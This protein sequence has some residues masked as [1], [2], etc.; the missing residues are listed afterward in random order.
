LYDFT[1]FCEIHY[2][3]KG[4][5]YGIFSS[6]LGGRRKLFSTCGRDGVVKH[7]TAYVGDVA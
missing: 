1:E 4:T 2:W 6:D 3:D 7:T 5:K